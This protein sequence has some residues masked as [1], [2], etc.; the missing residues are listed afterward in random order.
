MLEST[1]QSNSHDSSF[2]LEKLLELVKT[3]P[4]E[5]VYKTSDYF[6]DEVQTKTRNFKSK[7]KRHLK[8]FRKLYTRTIRKPWE[9]ALKLNNPIDGKIYV[10]GAPETIE[11]LKALQSFVNSQIDLPREHGK[12][13]QENFW[14]LLG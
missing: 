8:K 12:L 11:K 4:P 13:L 6:Y 14:D 3:I 2:N 1:S 9:N 5:I 10:I 7:K